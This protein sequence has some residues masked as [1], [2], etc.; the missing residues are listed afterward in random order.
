VAKVGNAWFVVVGSGPKASYTPNISTVESEGPGRI[1]VLNAE[2]GA[3]E[4]KF[5]LTTDDAYM[6]DPTAVDVDF[7]SKQDPDG[8]FN[9]EVVYIGET[10]KD[11]LGNW[12]GRMHRLVMDASKTPSSWTLSTFIDVGQPISASPSVAS[13]ADGN[14]WVF[15][16]TGRY[17]VNDDKTNT[18][19]QSFYG[20]IEP[21]WDGTTFTASCTTTVTKA[22]LLD[23]SDAE[24]SVGG[25]TV[26][27]V[28]GVSSF[29]ELIEEKVEDPSFTGWRLD[30]D[31]SKERNLSKASVVGGLVLFTTFIPD[32]T[33]VC[34]YG[35][36]SNLFSLFFRTG[37]AFTESTIGTEGSGG[38]ETVKKKVSLGK[39]ASSSL[40]IHIGRESGGKAF[41][42][43]S[44][45]AINDIDVAF[46]LNIRSG[47]ISWKEI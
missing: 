13:D 43:S 8:T 47:I 34:G 9:T 42:Q 38:S 4:N 36:T 16:G 29:N 20:V 41:I 22:S 44:T 3:L 45:G 32:A 39:G 31:E 11:N 21:C 1:F 37:T 2:T 26:T 7:I 14:F 5:D 27:G 15:F 19:Q 10:Y 28:A 46:A 12:K 33:D 35:G 18:D 6:A 23:V 25:D 24:V 17:H 40:G 30:F